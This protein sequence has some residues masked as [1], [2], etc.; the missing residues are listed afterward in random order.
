MAS[1]MLL[2]TASSVHVSSAFKTPCEYSWGE[3]L[4][5]RSDPIAGEGKRESGFP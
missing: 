5:P 2:S 4:V 1:P 3:C